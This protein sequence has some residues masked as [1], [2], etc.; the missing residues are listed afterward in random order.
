MVSR[1]DP[2]PSL[3]DRDAISEKHGPNKGPALSSAQKK[4][5]NSGMQM[6]KIRKRPKG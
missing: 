3:A 5:A 2:D 6:E 4:V 1:R